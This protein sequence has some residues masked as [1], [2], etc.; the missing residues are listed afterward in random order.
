MM[1]GKIIQKTEF[2]KTNKKSRIKN[3]V[4]YFLVAMAATFKVGKMDYVFSMSQPPILGGLL[5]VWGK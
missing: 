3:I 5:G 4:S 1:N 2:S